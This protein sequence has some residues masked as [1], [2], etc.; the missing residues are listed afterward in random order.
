MSEKTGVSETVMFS[1][2][3][4]IILSK[5]LPN[6]DLKSMCCVNRQLH[7]YFSVILQQDV[8]I[9]EQN[10]TRFVSS[11]KNSTHVNI[12]QIKG[13]FKDNSDLNTLFEQLTCT[14]LHL[15]SEFWTSSSD[16]NFPKQFAE[17]VL[18][19]ILEGDAFLEDVPLGIFQSL[20]S[21]TLNG[22]HEDLSLKIKSCPSI[23]KLKLMNCHF[24]ASNQIENY[25][26]GD[27][28]SLNA[29]LEKGRIDSITELNVY[30]S[31]V[32]SGGIEFDFFSMAPLCYPNLLKL[33]SYKSCI[34]NLK[35]L[36]NFQ[37]LEYFKLHEDLIK[38]QGV[39]CCGTLQYLYLIG[40]T[41]RIDDCIA[42]LK[43]NVFRI[44]CKSL[45][46]ESKIIK[47]PSCSV[48]E[49]ST[50]NGKIYKTNE[51]W[52]FFRNSKWTTIL[53]SDALMVLN[54]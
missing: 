26:Y 8:K 5:Y 16:F 52:Y 34:S 29:I 12:L 47:M 51:L 53:E 14:T 43:V 20:Q 32:S 50:R 30:N 54:K 27:R 23:H 24:Q 33:T 48:I 13:N 15:D 7:R 42:D 22:H 31:S 10:V 2:D 44:E 39:E 21:I 45:I 17:K 1:Y 41:I 28:Q 19:L 25:V 38:F 40:D 3:C 46:N 35:V 6:S 18:N 49:V 37:K 36:Q 11:M 4:S 9:N